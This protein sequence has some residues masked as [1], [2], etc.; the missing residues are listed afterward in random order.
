MA[1]S[2]FIPQYDDIARMTREGEIVA[3][4][5]VCG[6]SL[7]ALACAKAANDEPPRAEVIPL[8]GRT[9]A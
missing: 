9:D 4:D 1:S 7:L 8:K 3:D 5:C 2:C 6:V